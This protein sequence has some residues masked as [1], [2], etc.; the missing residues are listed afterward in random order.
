MKDNFSR[1]YDTAIDRDTLPKCFFT[2]KAVSSVN[3]KKT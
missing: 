2:G 3:Q 1:E